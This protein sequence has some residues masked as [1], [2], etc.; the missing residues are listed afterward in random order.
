MGQSNL[1]NLI[2]SMEVE[3]PTLPRAIINEMRDVIK[4]LVKSSSGDW[5]FQDVH[6]MDEQQEDVKDY[7]NLK[8][9]KGFGF[10]GFYGVKVSPE[11]LYLTD[12]D[13]HKHSHYH[14]FGDRPDIS[15]IALPT[16]KGGYDILRAFTFLDDREVVLVHTSIREGGINMISALLSWNAEKHKSFLSYYELLCKRY[17]SKFKVISHDGSVLRKSYEDIKSLLI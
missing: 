4:R 10:I 1:D 7:S 16:T 12:S 6:F 11:T 5:C 9:I 8:D 14:Q 3:L 17:I 13:Y 2:Q 15:V